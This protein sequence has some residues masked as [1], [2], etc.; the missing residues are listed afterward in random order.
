MSG[1]GLKI[2]HS[3]L[4]YV[5]RLDSRDSPDIDLLVIHCTELPDLATARQYGEQIHY[6]GSQTGNSGH[7][8]IDRDGSVHCWVPSNRVAHHAGK[9][10]A[11]SIGIELVNRGRWPDWFNSQNQVMAEPYPEPQ[12]KAL[13]KLISFLVESHP[14]VK[15]I[16]G[17]EDLDQSRIAASDAPG[18]L[19]KRKLDPGPEFPWAQVLNAVALNRLEIDQ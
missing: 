15:W 12:V 10:N 11:R 19:V 17:H 18:S 14:G 3:A 5:S 9:Y 4:P 13:I 1:V 6:E 8:Y 2:S 7:Y 16:T